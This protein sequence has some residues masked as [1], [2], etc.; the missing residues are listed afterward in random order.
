MMIMLLL[1]MVVPMA[2]DD[3]GGHGGGDRNDDASGDAD[4]PNPHYDA[5]DGYTDHSSLQLFII[6]CWLA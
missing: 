5:N 2:E 3:D 1:M 6:Q 4:A